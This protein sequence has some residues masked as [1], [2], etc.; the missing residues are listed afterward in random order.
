MTTK[1]NL[2]DQILKITMI[3]KSEFPE[4]LKYLNEM[5][6]TIPNEKLPEID[7]ATLQEY[8]D[9]LY[10]LLQKYAPNHLF[11]ISNN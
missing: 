9:S 7:A 10:D 5:P 11:I 2:N 3:I 8:Y 6:V 4:L 1:D